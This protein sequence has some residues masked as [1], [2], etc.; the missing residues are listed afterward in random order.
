MQYVRLGMLVL[1]CACLSGVARA[2]A[3]EEKDDEKAEHA[4][5]KEVLAGA[6]IDLAKAIETAQQK[7]A[8]G[9][10][11]YATTAKGSKSLRFD[12]FLLVGNGSVTEVRIDAASGKIKKIEEN[13]DEDV[14]DLD[15]AKKVLAASKITFAQAIATAKGKVEGG[16]PFE[17]E[18]DLEGG[19]SL[20]EVELMVGD[21]VMIVEIDAVTGEVVEVEE[22][23]E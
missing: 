14:E 8:G 7:I 10:P 15:D 12:V 23:K 3:E 19:K 1:M 16:K 11:I 9:K 21:K 2:D 4:V 13:E 20:I 17:V 18:T 22:E 5:A 6:K